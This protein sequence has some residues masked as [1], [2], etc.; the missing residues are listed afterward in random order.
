M[1]YRRPK[2][3]K[4]K[5]ALYQYKAFWVS[6]LVVLGIGGFGYFFLFSPVFKI[7][8]AQAQGDSVELQEKIISLVPKGNLFLFNSSALRQE[9]EATFPEIEDVKISRH[10]PHKVKVFFKKRVGVALWCAKASPCVS[11]DTNGVAFKDDTPG[12]EFLVYTADSPIVGQTITDKD[13]WALFLDFRARAEGILALEDPGAHFRSL[14]I[15]SETRANWET[16]EK[17]EV[18]IN[19]KENI[20][21][22]L[23]KL[24]AVLEKKIPPNRRSSLLYID[25]RFGDQAYIKYR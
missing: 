1:R 9:L 20:D 13:A 21:W 15:V 4:K 14:E 10:F 3:I 2:R 23:Q 24:Q 12:I 8:D 25:L 5:K 19:Q 6:F 17:W 16:L 22:Q 18:Y 7:T 11:V